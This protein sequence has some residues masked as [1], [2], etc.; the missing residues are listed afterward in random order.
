MLR[1]FFT[2][3][4]TLKQAATPPP[5]MPGMMPGAPPPQ[6]TAEPLPQSPLVPNAIAPP[7]TGM[8]A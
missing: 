1:D 4:Q 6:A 8:A 5:A 7:S 2:Q 3:I